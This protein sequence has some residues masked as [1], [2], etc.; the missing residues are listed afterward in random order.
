MIPLINLNPKW[1]GLLRP[2]SGEGLTLDCPK[3]GSTHRLAVY[4]SNPVDD[5]PAALWQNPTWKRTGNSFEAITI[6]PSIQYPCF[7]G[8]IEDGQ[9]IDIGESPANAIAIINGEQRLVAL[10]PKQYKELHET[11]HIPN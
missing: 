2:N 7:H 10:S 3:C 5:Q 4:F 6:E 11:L 1:I 9:V 8:W